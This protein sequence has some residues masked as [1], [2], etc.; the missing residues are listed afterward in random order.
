MQYLTLQQI[1]SQV[2]IATLDGF[3]YE[4]TI[5]DAGGFMV[6]GVVRDG[7]TL[8]EPGFRIV[9]GSPLIPYRYMENGNFTF[10]IPDDEEPDYNQFE[11]TQFLIYAS[12]E[13]LD[14]IR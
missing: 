7:E 8:L 5:K 4:I 12:P 10:E 11:S 14:S 2:V 3:R 13:E 9:N 1:P 6:C